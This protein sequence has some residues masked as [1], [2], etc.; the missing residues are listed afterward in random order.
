MVG[1]VGAGME[2]VDLIH[3]QS[4]GGWSHDGRCRNISKVSGDTLM[5]L[6]SRCEA[7]GSVEPEFVGLPGKA[8]TLDATRRLRFI[9]HAAGWLHSTV[10]YAC[11]YYNNNNNNNGYF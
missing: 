8:L 5:T 1:W 11:W 7:L 3:G 10:V 9:V 6:P 4:Q 2:V